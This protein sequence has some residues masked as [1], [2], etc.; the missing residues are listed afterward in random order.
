MFIHLSTLQDKIQTRPDTTGL[1]A[2]R[3]RL[4]AKTLLRCDFPLRD[5]Y[6][7]FNPITIVQHICPRLTLN[8]PRLSRSVGLLSCSTSFPL[9]RPR[10]RLTFVSDKQS[11]PP[12]TPLKRGRRQARGLIP[13]LWRAVRLQNPYDA[14]RQY[15][16]M[17][18]TL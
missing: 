2:S 12:I 15:M 14:K 5:F 1:S 3:Q 6:D 11:E 18:S 7:D 8:G 10:A 4:E 13:F 17:L 9:C 16:R